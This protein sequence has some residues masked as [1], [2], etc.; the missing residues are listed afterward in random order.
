MSRPAVEV[1]DILRAQGNRFL[2]RYEK[3]FD[4]QQLKAFR[5]I[6]RCR[7]AALGGHIDACPRCG[8]QAAISYNSCRNRHCPKC[9]AQARDHWIAARESDLLATDYFH[10]VFTVPHELN[11]L[12]LDNQPLFYDLLFKASAQTLLEV[13]VDPKHLAPKSA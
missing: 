10:V 6:Q 2:D 3:S 8:Y 12:A 13:A 1:A 5:A 9:Q 11:V 4:F 7:T